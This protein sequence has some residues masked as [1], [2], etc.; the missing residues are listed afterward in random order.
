MSKNV[1]KFILENIVYWHGCPA[2]IQ[3]NGGKSYVSQAIK[4]FLS[5]YGLK[6][7]VTAA[8]HP[9]NNGLAERMIK[10]IKAGLSKLLI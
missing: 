6:H 7:S 10:T 1:I 3:T 9:E 5:W 4:T 2:Y 8:Y